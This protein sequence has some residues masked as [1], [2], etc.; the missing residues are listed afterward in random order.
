L[1]SFKEKPMKANT[2]L[3]LL[4]QPVDELSFEKIASAS[5]TKEAWDKLEKAYKGDDPVRKVRLQTLRGELEV[6]KMKE[7]EGVSDYITRVQT[8]VNQLKRNGENLPDSRI[9][10]K[11]LRGRVRGRGEHEHCPNVDCYNCGRHG[12]YAKDCRSA[13]RTE[14]NTN[15]VIEPRVEE[16][17]VLLMAQEEPV[18]EVDMMWYLVSGA[19]HH[20]SGQRSLFTEQKETFQ[21]HVSFDD[22]S[23]IKAKGRGNIHFLNAGKERS[24]KGKQTS[25]SFPRNANYQAK[26]LRELIHSDL[27]GP[28]SPVSFGKRYF[29]T[30][31]KFKVM[32]EKTTCQ[33]IKALR[34]DS[35]GEYFVSFIMFCEEQG[36]MRSG[37]MCGIHP[38]QISSCQIDGY[39]PSRMLER[40]EAYGLSFQNPENITFEEVRSGRKQWMNKSMQLKGIKREVHQYKVRL[41][42]KGYR[43]KVG[44]DYDEIF[45]PVA[46]METI[47]L[48]ISLAAQNHWNIYQMDVKSAFLNGVL[49]EI[50]YIEQPSSYAKVREEN[51]VLKLKKAFYGLKQALEPRILLLTRF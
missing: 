21:G 48:L 43:Q 26:E 38:E 37:S 12:H 50:F 13:K 1:K 14:E 44:I 19:S 3:F 31:K 23:K 10:E 36:I 30:F 29:V 32:V 2:A 27:C 17:G 40:C 5:T 28:F 41:V 15:L 35:G 22:A 4:F 47:R 25:S 34:S 46:R 24:I 7:E 20:M 18:L 11:I 9:I 51:K 8:M 33:Y 39:D 49:D 6:V 16:G 42:A 45:T